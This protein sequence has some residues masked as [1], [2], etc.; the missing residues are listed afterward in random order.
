MLFV[1]VIRYGSRVSPSAADVEFRRREL[2]G[3]VDVDVP[4]FDEVAHVV[5]RAVVALFAHAV[6]R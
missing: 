5:D 2:I 4:D 6:L 3:N 1:P